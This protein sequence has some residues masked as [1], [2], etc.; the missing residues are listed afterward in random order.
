M[1]ADAWATALLVLGHERG[2]TIAEDQGIAVLFI[3]N[4]EGVI[5]GYTSSHFGGACIRFYSDFIATFLVMGLALIAMAIRVIG[6]RQPLAGSCGGLGRMGLG[7]EA[8]CDQSCAKHDGKI[9]CT[10]MPDLGF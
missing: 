6:G 2:L 7:C 8:G 3:V 1:V 5:K 9:A 4:Q 10:K